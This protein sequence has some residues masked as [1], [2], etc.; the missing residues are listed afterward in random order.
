[1]NYLFFIYFYAYFQLFK[2]V[3]SQPPPLGLALRHHPN[4]L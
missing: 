4:S 3:G 1:M 2:V